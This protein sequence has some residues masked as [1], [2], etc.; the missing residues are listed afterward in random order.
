MEKYELPLSHRSTMRL[1]T[2]NKLVKSQ[3]VAFPIRGD[4]LLDNKYYIEKPRTWDHDPAWKGT[5]K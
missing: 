2:I 3:D 1:A 5:K 4:S